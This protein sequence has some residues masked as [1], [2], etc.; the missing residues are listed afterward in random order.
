MPSIKQMAPYKRRSGGANMGSSVQISVGYYDR[1]LIKA[2]ENI[3]MEINHK[4]WLGLEIQGYLKSQ[5]IPAAQEELKKKDPSTYDKVLPATRKFKQSKSIYRRV[6]ESLDA[7]ITAEGVV[8]AGSAPFPHGV[9]GSRQDA[10][11]KKTIAQVV[12]RG[13]R[14][15]VY[16][17]KKRLTSL[18]PIVRSSISYGN[19][20]RSAGEIPYSVST[21]LPMSLKGKHP[22]F[23]GRQRF[24]YTAFMEKMIREEF[25]TQW[26]PRR[27]EFLGEVYGFKRKA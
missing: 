1:G 13:M 4:N 12:K 23:T 10:G 27:L 19:M 6:A 11:T 22:G 5:V 9:A 15:F 2:M 14:P 16:K 7:Q 18:P 3:D 17:K 20:K 8:M 21:S 25:K 24:D 26:M